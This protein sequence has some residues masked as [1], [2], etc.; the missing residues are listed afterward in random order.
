ML[1]A[2]ISA[3]TTAPQHD[4]KKVAQSFEALFI[5]QILKSA[6]AAA[7]SDDPLLGEGEKTFRDMRDDALAQAMAA[8]A[9]LGVARALG[10]QP[11][12][13]TRKPRP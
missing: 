13:P 6:H 2:R 9:P 10:L 11:A 5:A 7:L 4:L 8:T 1:I 12:N 3:S